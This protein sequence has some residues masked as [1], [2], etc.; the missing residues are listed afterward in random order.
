MRC[1]RFGLM[2]TAL[3]FL[4]GFATAIA[5]QPLAQGQSLMPDLNNAGPPGSSH[6]AGLAP[7]KYDNTTG[8]GTNSKNAGGS[9]PSSTNDESNT[10]ESDDQLYHGRTSESENPMLRDEGRLHF[11]S[12]PKEKVQEVDSLKNL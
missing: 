10:D 7:D 8:L 2:K 4:I 12:R 9:A 1:N 6:A 11:K 5:S 3:P